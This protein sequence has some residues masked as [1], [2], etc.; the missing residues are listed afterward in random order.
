MLSQPADLS[1]SPT[2]FHEDPTE[3]FP[4]ELCSQ[5]KKMSGVRLDFSPSGSLLGGRQLGPLG[6]LA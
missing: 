2:G 1:V 6:K 5:R 3:A 4:P